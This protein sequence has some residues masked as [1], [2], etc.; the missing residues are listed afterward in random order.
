LTQF[1]FGSIFRS[2]TASQNKLSKLCITKVKS[3]AVMLI[4]RY[5]SRTLRTG[6]HAVA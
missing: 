2:T 4:G 5:I 6:G 3:V 1:L